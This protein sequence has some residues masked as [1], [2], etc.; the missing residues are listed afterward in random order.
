MTETGTFA[1]HTE[2][3]VPADRSNLV[4]RAFETLHPA[5]G[6]EFRIT[7]KIPLSGG[8]GSSAAAVRRR[9][10]GRRSHVRARRRRDGARHRARGPSGQRRRR[11]CTAA[12]SSAPATQVHRFEPPLGLE[13]VLVVPH[14]PVVTAA[15]ARG[16]ARPGSARRRRAQRGVGRDAGARTGARGLR[17]DR[18]RSRRPAPSALPRLAV[19]ALGGAARRGAASLGALGATISGAGPTVLVWCRFEQTGGVVEALT[20]RTRG[21]GDGDASAVREPGRRRRGRCSA[22]GGGRG[23]LDQ[24]RP[25]GVRAGSSPRRRSSSSA[26]FR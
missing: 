1:V 10:A 2:L 20:R 26:T 9:A 11:R 18:R 14:E 13:A 19:S 8:L 15:G 22:S 7:S 6:I 5:D 3:P 25:A 23:V 24:L 21:L 16:A 17:A 4:V 12:S